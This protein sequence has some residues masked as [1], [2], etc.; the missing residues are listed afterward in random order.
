M[1]WHS[2][3][4]KAE[5]GHADAL[6]GL[7]KQAEQLSDTIETQSHRI[8]ELGGELARAM[9]PARTAAEEARLRQA[10]AALRIHGP[11]AIVILRH[12]QIHGMLTFG[13]GYPPLP[14]G[15]SGD[16]THMW[17]RQLTGD[18]LVTVHNEPVS[19]G[20]N[21]VFQIAPGMV[22]ILD[23]LLYPPTQ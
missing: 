3:T 5:K 19:G 13:S 10:Q 2:N 16:Q 23:E 6:A 18:G 12:L 7:H 21:Y 9:Q 22:A 1:E 4:S 20:C 15:F 11:D 14:N 17:L 8:T